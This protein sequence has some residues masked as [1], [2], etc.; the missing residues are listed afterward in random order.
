MDKNKIQRINF[1]A[2]KSKAAGLTATEQEE[3]AQLR[4][5]YIEEYKANLRMQLENTYVVDESGNKSKLGS[6][7]KK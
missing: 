2:K 4:R 6:G 5:E 7:D 1:L 3:Q